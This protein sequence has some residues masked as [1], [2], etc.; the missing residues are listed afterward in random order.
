MLFAG[1]RAHAGEEPE[2][3]VK[4]EPYRKTVALRASVRG[5]YRVPVTAVL[6][7][8]PL[9]GNDA[10]PV[11]GSIALDLFAGKMISIDFPAKQMVVESP[12]TL[13]A[14]IARAKRLPVSL[15]RE[16]QGRA[17][18][19]SLGVLTPAGMVWFELDSGNGGT[20]LVSKAYAHLFGLDPD[21]KGLQH[22]DFAVGGGFR[23]RGD[24]FTPDMILDANLGM[25]FLR[26]KVVTLDLA[27]GRLWVTGPTPP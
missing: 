14:R 23:A 11:D 25:P 16:L 26:D 15:A 10:A 24:T 7:V 9:V 20:L 19:A 5:Q 2:D 3:V 18:A 1:A 8:A 13:A 17:L 22:A 4:L 27:Q 12:Q 21:K 6:D